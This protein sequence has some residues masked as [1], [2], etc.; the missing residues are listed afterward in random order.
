MILFAVSAEVP[1]GELFIAGFG[2]GVLICVA[3]IVYVWLWAKIKGHGKND[4]DGK[5]PIST[6][7]ADMMLVLGISG[8]YLLI[9]YSAASLALFKSGGANHMLATILILLVVLGVPQIRQRLIRPAALPLIMPI[10]IST[11]T[12]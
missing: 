9:N 12:H 2:P 11:K 3:L 10:Y 4:A 7:M 1:V 5:G 6:A 8:L